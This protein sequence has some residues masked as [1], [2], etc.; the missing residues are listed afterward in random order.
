M[1]KR[2][3]IIGGARSGKST[4]AEN[5]AESF[6]GMKIYLATAQARDEEMQIRIA[7][8]QARRDELWRTIEEPTDICPIL[9]DEKYTHSL[10]LVDCLTLWLSNLMES[11]ADIENE[12]HMLVHAI[13]H[14]K[15]RL[16]IVSNEV[17][18]GIVPDNALAREFRDH[19]G[20]INQQV[21]AACDE[22][23]FMAAGLP[24]FMKGSAQ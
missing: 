13:T 23:V 16:V 18:L 1:S 4:F 20:R 6:D 22:V 17:G 10:I 24:L 8:H 2:S 19:A 5:I 14:C 12:T 7:T 11:H 3:F 21:A 9:V 15:A